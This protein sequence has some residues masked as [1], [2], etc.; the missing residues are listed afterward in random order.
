[1][2]AAL[3]TLEALAVFDGPERPVYRRVAPGPGGAIVLD[4]CDPRWRAAVI[5]P[6]GWE[7]LDRAPVMFT[8]GNTM[9]ALPEPVRGGQLTDLRAFLNLKTYDDW[10]L[11]AAWLAAALG[12]TGPYPVLHARGEQG[13][14]KT[15]VGR[16]L[17]RLI[18]PNDVEL[19]S[20]PRDERDLAVSSKHGWVLGYDNLSTIPRWL[21][22]ALCRVATGG[23]FGTRTLFT[24]DEETT[25]DFTRPVLITS[26]EDVIGQPDLLDRSLAV[27]LDPIS[28]DTR[29][30]EA[31]LWAAFDAARPSLL[32]G[33]LEVV[34]R[35]L[36]L[37]PGVAAE[38]MSI[39]RM[40]DFAVFGEAVARALGEAPGHFLDVLRVARSG[41]D[42]DAIEGS[43]AAQVLVHWIRAR[44]WFRGTSTQLLGE[45]NT[46]AAPGARRQSN[47]PTNAQ[48][49]GGLVR[50][51]TPALR[52][53]GVTVRHEKVGHERTRITT[54]TFDPAAAG[55]SPSASP[56]S[57]GKL[58]ARRDFRAD[59]V[60]E[61]ISSA[62][63]GIVPPRSARRR[64]V[65]AAD[66]VS[67]RAGAPL[68]TPS[69][70]P[71]AGRTEP[72]LLPAD[73]AD[74]PPPGTSGRPEHASPAIDPTTP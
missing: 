42:A 8:R 37:R 73:T 25:F 21:S 65:G 19:R 32:G 12:P 56:P 5:R 2:T 27:E 49:L 33:L 35:A 11:V 18:D 7:V 14:A 67:S 70:A 1:M 23:G 72:D 17:R 53:L 64:A 31:E 44:H 20:H 15:T 16:I 41:A 62:A 66:E 58:S 43:S 71:R 55:H 60:M 39:P 57:A 30:T 28:D 22:D 34:A 13:A 48:A 24:D 52:R 68:L 74:D 4:L 61:P 54:I 29:R 59:D 45:L 3:A 10:L 46:A 50:R 26:I 38:N 9:R 63:E 47:W 36:Q 40:A 51:I 69:S 6:G